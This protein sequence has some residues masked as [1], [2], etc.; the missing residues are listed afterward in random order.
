MSNNQNYN[1][2]L[3]A[4]HLIKKRFWLILLISMSVVFALL[5]LITF[6][7]Y[8]K[9]NDLKKANIL[10]TDLIE[11]SMIINQAFVEK[12]TIENKINTNNPK[13][14]DSNLQKKITNKKIKIIP[15][16]IVNDTYEEIIFQSGDNLINVLKTFS[17]NVQTSIAISDALGEIIPS[18][19][20]R[21]GDKI[22]ISFSKS[23]DKTI[24]EIIFTT[25]NEEILIKKNLNGDYKAAIVPPIL[26]KKYSLKNLTI[27][28][29]MYKT[30]LENN[31]PLEVINKIITNH[32]QDINFNKDIRDG[33]SVI[34]FYSTDINST[35]NTTL[36]YKLI[37]SSITY[38][39]GKNSEYFR[40]KNISG[41]ESFYNADGV[42]VNR[43]IFI[44]PIQNSKITSGYGM[45]MHPVLRY[46]KMHSGDDYRAYINQPVFATADGTI[47]FIGEKGD[48]GNYI[49][50]NHKN[51]I[52][53]AYAH[54]NKYNKNIK[55]GDL[56]KQ[57]EVIAYAGSSGL[58]TGTH[59]H[60]EIIRDR[61]K[62]NPEIFT[63]ET[64]NEYLENNDL[65]A[66]QKERN[67][68]I[69]LMEV[70]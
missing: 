68:I 9:M 1:I 31:I 70:Y 32:S 26:E 17:I 42:S 19:L 41:N 54:L 56:I 21:I 40:Y 67:K 6:I 44:K 16:E 47:D 33:D 12:E 27:N 53:T 63:K 10:K 50:I 48:Y 34:I 69:Q 59:L 13:I 51:G 25:K 37:Y 8:T 64:A 61:E 24:K 66:F 3:N 15:I 49:R 5:I 30:A 7:N 52:Q 14:I 46:E 29:A 60:Y 4:N 18:N 43:I 38:K 28:G 36:E 39:N 20:I 55:N 35:N 11:N 22:K 57:G 2:F 23:N 45:R 62:I 65:R 58:S